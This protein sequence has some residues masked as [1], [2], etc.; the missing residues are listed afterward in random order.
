MLY[1]T[2]KERLGSS[3][4]PC[5]CV[6]LSRIIRRIDGLDEL[7]APFT[8]DEIDVVIKEMS[9]D[10]APGP[11]R[12]NGCILKICWHIIKEDFYRMFIQYQ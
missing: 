12:F 1:K 5:M 6:D 10:R 3:K 8:K 11:D 4:T 7:S 9:A 2:Y